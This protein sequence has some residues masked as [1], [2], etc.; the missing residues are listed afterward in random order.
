MKKKLK[1][2]VAGLTTVVAIGGGYGLWA[3]GM[4]QGMTMGA[5]MSSPVSASG[6]AAAATGSTEALPQTI[7]QGEEATRRHISSGIKAG[8]VDPVTGKL[9]MPSLSVRSGL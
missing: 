9:L 6:G 8:D 4:S 5:A 7:A 1:W 2:G 3:V